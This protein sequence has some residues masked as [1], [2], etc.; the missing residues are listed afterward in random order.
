[1]CFYALGLMQKHNLSKIDW[2][3][4]YIMSGRIKSYTIA[5]EQASAMVDAVWQRKYAKTKP[6]VNYHCNKCKN[7]SKCPA[8]L[9]T[10]NMVS[11][12]Y[13]GVKD[14]DSLFNPWEI[15]SGSEMSK[16]LTTCKHVLGPF[17]KELEKIIKNVSAAAVELSRSTSIPHYERR[18]TRKRSIKKI[19]QTQNELGF[20]NDQMESCL[21]LSIGE[22]EKVYKDVVGAKSVK[23]AKEQF[24]ENAWHLIEFE[25]P[26][27]SMKFVK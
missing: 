12:V 14:D 9:K 15:N 26:T 24:A 23:A 7:L 25:E 1:M 2:C 6:Q 21:R 18:E 5:Y 13:N 17:Q 11:D 22:L 19:F 10:V 16:V 3:E 8:V 20:S 27:Y 4:C